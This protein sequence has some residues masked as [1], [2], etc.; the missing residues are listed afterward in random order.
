M[1][2]PLRYTNAIERRNR[3]AMKGDV[4]NLIHTNSP[5]HSYVVALAAKIKE[6]IQP[7]VSERATMTSQLL[8]LAAY[9]GYLNTKGARLAII[10]VTSQIVQRRFVIGASSKEDA[11]RQ[12]E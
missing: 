11:Y 4:N 12:Y 8:S 9:R 5:L 6:V 7:D 10:P 2:A 1:A 3:E